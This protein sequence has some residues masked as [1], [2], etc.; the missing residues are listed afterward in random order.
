MGLVLAVT[1][2]GGL[3]LLMAVAVALEL[4]HCLVLCIVM[5]PVWLVL[6]GTPLL[7]VNK[8]QPPN[9]DQV[10]AYFVVARLSMAV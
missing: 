3:S 6:A 9:D 5:L 7:L 8:R 10:N 4:H 2:D 1:R